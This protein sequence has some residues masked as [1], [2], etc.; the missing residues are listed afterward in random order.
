MPRNICLWASAVYSIN[1]FFCSVAAISLIKPLFFPSAA[2]HLHHVAILTCLFGLYFTYNKNLMLILVHKFA[3][4]EPIHSINWC[5]SWAL[6]YILLKHSL[7]VLMHFVSY[8]NSSQIVVI[9]HELNL[10]RNR[11]S[12]NWALRYY[13]TMSAYMVMFSEWQ[14]HWL[15]SLVAH[16]NSLRFEDIS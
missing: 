6:V 9:F 2:W 7:V 12:D 14:L 16:N 1:I 15:A 4:M 5:S 13:Y 3:S 11:F 10:E 8:P